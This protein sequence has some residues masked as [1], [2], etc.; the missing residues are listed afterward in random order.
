MERTILM[1]SRYIGR[2]P[3]TGKPCFFLQSLDL[4]EQRIVEAELSKKKEDLRDII[5]KCNLL[6]TFFDNCPVLMG[7]IQLI[8]EDTKH[9]KS[10]YENNAKLLT[11]L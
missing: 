10:A 7:T 3:T 4:T 9:S 1:R 6:K 2:S 8:E 11:F 5:E